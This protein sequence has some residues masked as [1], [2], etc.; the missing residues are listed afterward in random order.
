MP[1]VCP[2][3]SGAEPS[4]SGTRGVE[5]HTHAQAAAVLEP[6]GSV[7]GPSASASFERQAAG[8]IAWPRPAAGFEGGGQLGAARR[9]GTPGPPATAMAARGPGGSRGVRRGATRPRPQGCRLADV[10]RVRLL[11]PSAVITYPELLHRSP[12][13]PMDHSVGPCQV[14]PRPRSRHPA[15]IQGSAEGGGSTTRGSADE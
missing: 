7:R 2:S 5:L 11:L 6:D 13:L 4:G 10:H 8:T 14:A 3:C 15:A 9:S 1:R 12:Q